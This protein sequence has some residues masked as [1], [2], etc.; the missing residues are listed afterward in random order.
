MLVLHKT[1]P[2]SLCESLALLLSG[3]QL[4]AFGVFLNYERR[5]HDHKD[6][7]WDARHHEIVQVIMQRRSTL[8]QSW[9]SLH[10]DLISVALGQPDNLLCVTHIFNQLVGSLTQ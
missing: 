3:N 8:L 4:I 7:T 1:K 5:I 10:N 2:D 6:V 9:I